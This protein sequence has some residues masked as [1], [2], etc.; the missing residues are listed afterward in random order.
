MNILEILF[1]IVACA[2]SLAAFFFV[3]SVALAIL[4]VIVATINRVVGR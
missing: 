2:L 3:A 1:S 4:N